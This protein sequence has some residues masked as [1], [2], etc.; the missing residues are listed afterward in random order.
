MRFALLLALLCS[1]CMPVVQHGPWVRRGG[2]GSIGGTAAVAADF[3]EDGSAA[4][5]FSFEG[6]MR[7][8]W[9]PTDSSNNGASLGL[10]LPVVALFADAFEDGTDQ[11][12][13]F[14]QFLNLDG[15]VTGPRLGKHLTAAGL[16]LSRYHAMP[17]IQFGKLDDWYGTASLLLMRE[18]NTII[19]APSFTDVRRTGERSVT[20]LTFTAGMGMGGDEVAFIAGLS[21]IFEFHRKNASP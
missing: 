21:L 20:H 9:T 13:G 4:P 5:F 7:A 6:G 15:Y 11:A 3:G 12:F 1:G 17:Y 18:D 19:F 14:L 10:Q 16:T 8:G 2:S